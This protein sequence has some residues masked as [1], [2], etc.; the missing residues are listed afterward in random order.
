MLMQRY[1]EIEIEGLFQ[2]DPCRPYHY[3]A[4]TRFLHGS[5]RSIK[6]AAT[7]SGPVVCAKG[8]FVGQGEAFSF[9]QT[10]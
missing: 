8:F 5:R 7:M 10:P 1:K 3:H 6:Q 4:H 9:Q 2:I